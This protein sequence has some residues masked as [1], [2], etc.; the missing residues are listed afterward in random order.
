MKPADEVKPVLATPE[1]SGD[2]AVIDGKA[3]TY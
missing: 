3:L 2:I 1:L